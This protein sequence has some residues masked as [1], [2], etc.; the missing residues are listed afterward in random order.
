MKKQLQLLVK[1][2]K[3]IR[4]VQEHFFLE[5]K[6]MLIV[7]TIF[8]WFQQFFSELPNITNKLEEAVG[9]VPISSQILENQI[10]NMFSRLHDITRKATQRR[11]RLK[12][13]EHKV[14]L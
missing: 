12:Y 8:H 1:N 3:S 7:F 11:I 6:C 14:K 2:W 5:S 9:T 4:L 10:N 13:L